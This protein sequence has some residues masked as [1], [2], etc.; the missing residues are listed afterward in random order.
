[1]VIAT[2]TT[3]LPIAE[4]VVFSLAAVLHDLRGR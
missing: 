4:P 1:M 2:S 3:F